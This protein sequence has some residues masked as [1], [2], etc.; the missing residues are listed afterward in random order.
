MAIEKS[1]FGF[2]KKNLENTQ[3]WIKNEIKLADENDNELKKK[4]AELKK[5]SRGRY[6]EELETSQKLYEITHKN[7]EKYIE[8]KDEPYFAR[9]DFKE[10][11]KD[12][13]S[14]YIG[15]FGLGDSKTGDE[16]VIDWRAPISDLYYSK[17]QGETSYEI[18]D[19]FIDGELTLKRKFL[20]RDTELVDAFDEGINEIILKSGDSESALTDEF[21]KINLEESVSSK[22]KDVVATIQKEQN[23]I[24]RAGKNLPLIVQGSAGSGK[25]TIA[26]HRLAYLLYK[27]NKTLS[28]K[29][30]LV[31]APNKIFLDYISMVLPSL[32]IDKVMQLTFE[33]LAVKTL[34]IKGKV[35]TK[36]KKLSAV[37][38]SKE[39]Q[40][41]LTESSKL[42]GSLLYKAI[43]DR[44]IRYIEIEDAEVED[45]KVDGS[46][47][48]KAADIKRLFVK[49]MQHLPLDKRKDEIKRYFKIK[50]KERLPELIEKISFN[51]EYVIARIKK[52]E[53][54][55]PDRRKKITEIYN[56]RD[57]KK[58]E[59]IKLS[60][61]S[62]DG[63]FEKWKHSDTKALL[64]KMLK[65]KEVLAKVAEETVPSKLWEYIIKEFE[66]NEENGFMDSDDL[67][68]I[69]Y[70]KFKIEG[71]PEGFTF[72]HIVI[73][74]AQDYSAFQYAVIRHMASNDSFT[75]VGDTGQGIYYYKGINS[76]QKLIKDVFNSSA[77]YVQLTQSYRSTVEIIDFAN[78]VLAKQENSLKPAKP[79]LRHGNEP[80]IIEFKGNKEFGIKLD[81]IVETCHGKGKQ[82]VAVIG[83]TYEECKYINAFLK[84]YS[85]HKWELI[86]D[87]DK[88]VKLEKIIIPSYMTK[89]LEFDCSVIYNCNE[90]NYA[91][92]ELDKKILY[93]ALTR[94]LHLEYVCFEEKI[95]PLL[96]DNSILV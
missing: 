40:N 69:M 86:K 68:A 78:K 43:L 63:Y 41:Y 32:G 82:S 89:G 56:E 15:K 62:I 37:I 77:N 29:D 64:Y 38:E 30:I 50:I 80:E 51:Y 16:I 87:T 10:K 12:N 85:K 20:I 74:E 79:V 44:Y 49:D 54:D 61:E 2:E 42:K 96:E 72:R 23:D 6:S 25:T 8:V 9:I 21:L 31:I 17:T 67:T 5:E 59:I 35:L 73:D 27:Y 7:L 14:F 76:W 46:T 91:D 94:A 58:K 71:V 36:D 48:F 60:K 95:S 83:R 81:D 28:G 75:I 57:A 92:N 18:P 22:L 19:G 93:V 53:E 90:E 11:R 70:L 33:E 55:S 84:K 24:I 66:S 47:I 88:N 65:N 39:K 3:K 1:E 45:I 52:T 34:Q 4:I 13:E 26:L